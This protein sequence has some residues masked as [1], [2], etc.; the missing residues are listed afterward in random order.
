[1]KVNAR[2]GRLICWILT[3]ALLATSCHKNST[4]VTSPLPPATQIGANMLACYL[5]TTPLILENSQNTFDFSAG[6]GTN[7]TFYIAGAPA[8][9]LSYF[10]AIHY[11]QLEIFNNPEI[12]MPYAANDSTHINF[13]YQTDSTCLIRS[14]DAPIFT[15]CSGTVTIT[16]LDN[17]N[18]IMSGVF[19]VKFAIPGCDSVTLSDGWFD[20]RF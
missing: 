9:T 4:P 15:D 18:R 11:L 7:D 8:P 16:K 3:G 14:Y 12:G 1:M 10:F 19:N 2:F 20:F 6:R 17:N 13:Q 5:D